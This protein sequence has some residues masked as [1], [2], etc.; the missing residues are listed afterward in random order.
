[1]LRFELVL[2]FLC[3]STTLGE[4]LKFIPR[5]TWPPDFCNK[6]DCPKY[7]VLEK[8][9]DYELRLYESSGWMSSNTAGIDYKEASYTNFRRLFRYINGT[10]EKAEKIAM[11]A[12]VLIM[13]QPGP[14][15]A[16][17]NNF[18]MSFFMSPKVANPPAPTE[19]GVF[20]QKMPQMKVYVRSF[21]GYVISIN[22]WLEEAK[23]LEEAISAKEAGKFHTE[24]FFTA[25]YNSPF[26]IF[27]RHNEI[28]FIA[29]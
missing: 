18:T 24:F 9:K 26:Q 22:T 16:C 19:K 2:F 7:Q 4:V 15:P 11:T 5:L 21:S 25:G 20:P 8:N 10:N 17:E 28:W 3:I 14:G 1:M 12:P 6:L 27:N 29:K 23:K 13:V